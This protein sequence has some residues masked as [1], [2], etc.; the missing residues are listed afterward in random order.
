[1]M[2]VYVL[3]C[4]DAVKVGMSNNPVFRIRYLEKYTPTDSRFRFLYSELDNLSER[5]I[6]FMVP[7]PDRKFAKRVERYAHWLM[8]RA[9]MHGEWFWIE[10][11]LACHCVLMGLRAVEHGRDKPMSNVIS[12]WHGNPAGIKPWYVDGIPRVWAA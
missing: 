4:R 1:M 8:R 11:E 9:N 2:Y 6:M 10:P 12:G 5:Q 3:K 7:V